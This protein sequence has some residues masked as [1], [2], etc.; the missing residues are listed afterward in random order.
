MIVGFLIGIVISFFITF[1]FWA[2]IELGDFFPKH[3][4]FLTIFCFIIT[5]LFSIFLGGAIDNYCIESNI[6][7]YE[8]A[9]QTYVSSL[10]ND[11]VSDYEKVAI[12]QTVMEINQE[13]AAS[14]VY[15]NSIWSIGVTEENKEAMNNIQFIGE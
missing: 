8:A 13:I 11:Q 7:K 6:A 14:K 3:K 9:A 2:I 5:L 15:V 12:R 4:T 1:L 10:E